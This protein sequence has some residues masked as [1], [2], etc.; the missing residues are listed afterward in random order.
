MVRCA[1]RPI[2]AASRCLHL[3]PSHVLFLICLCLQATLTTPPSLPAAAL[4]Q[5]PDPTIP[6]P[7]QRASSLVLL[8]RPKQSQ[9]DPDFGLTR[10]FR[11]YLLRCPTADGGSGT[12]LDSTSLAVFT[13]AK[14]S[15]V[16]APWATSS[17]AIYPR[18]SYLPGILSVLC[19][20]L[21]ER[22]HNLTPASAMTL[23]LLS[24]SKPLLCPLVLFLNTSTEPLRLAVGPSSLHAAQHLP[25]RLV[26]RGSG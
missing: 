14:V 8:R 23:S 22:A 9:R 5:C 3:T 18:F 11:R 17:N 15:C 24:D 16:F 7:L 25:A 12:C 1:F 2:S 13:D 20:H 21:T 6:R 4:G 10:R 26:P 19:S